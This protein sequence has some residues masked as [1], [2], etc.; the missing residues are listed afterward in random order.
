LT[1]AARFT[2]TFGAGSRRENI[3]VVAKDGRSI[4][5]KAAF[6]DL[7]ALDK[8]LRSVTFK[9]FTYTKLCV[10]ACGNKTEC[11]GECAVFGHPL[12]FY[13][14]HNDSNQ[15][16]FRPKWAAADGVEGSCPTTFLTA[17][18]AAAACSVESRV[19][20][21]LG[22]DATLW[23]PASPQ[24]INTAGMLG[25]LEGHTTSTAIQWFVHAC[26]GVCLCVCI[27]VTPLSPRQELPP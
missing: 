9:D 18:A 16:D 13:R 25:S 19:A 20:S 6:E 12:E 2:R 7:A 27:C 26:M 11:P 23:P 3:I 15:F 21:G 8:K 10:S 4:L 17:E 5:T 22:I 1:D 14:V 24:R